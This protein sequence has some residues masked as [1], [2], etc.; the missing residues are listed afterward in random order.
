MTRNIHRGCKVLTIKKGMIN[1]FNYALRCVQPLY[2]LSMS[3][4]GDK[5][6]NLILG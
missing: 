5:A 1:H 4:F 3:R 6:K 2:R